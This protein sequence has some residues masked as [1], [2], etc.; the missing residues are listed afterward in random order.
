MIF[1]VFLLILISIKYLFIVFREG[2]SSR[3]RRNDKKK[4][5]Q[6]ERDSVYENALLEAESNLD[7]LLTAPED[8]KVSYDDSQYETHENEFNSC[9]KDFHQTSADNFNSN[10]LNNCINN[11]KN[12]TSE[13]GL[14]TGHI[15][16]TSNFLDKI[17]NTYVINEES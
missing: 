9:V 13:I 11:T 7:S 4:E 5:K 15:T 1:L 17:V 12:R 10:N 3:R 14:Y 6:A 16:N 8:M 2:A